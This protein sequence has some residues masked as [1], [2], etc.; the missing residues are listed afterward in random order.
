M[1]IWEFQVILSYFLY[2]LY[3]ICWLFFNQNES[4]PI[5]RHH[6]RHY[7]N[8]KP[9]WPF[10]VH[11]E[12]FTF[13]FSGSPTILFFLKHCIMF[14]WKFRSSNLHSSYSNRKSDNSEEFIVFH[15]IFQMSFSDRRLKTYKI[16]VPK[17]GRRTHTICDVIETFHES[18][19]KGFS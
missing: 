18:V 16:G 12:L 7:L 1:H 14:Y 8:S 9:P 11:R 6:N 10:S 13:H 17:A 2:E 4:W 15:R 3:M 19:V 5:Q